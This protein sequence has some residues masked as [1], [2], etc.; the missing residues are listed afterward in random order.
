MFGNDEACLKAGRNITAGVRAGGVVRSGLLYVKGG[1]SNGRAT[2]SYR[3]NVAPVNNFN[4]SGN[5]DGWHVGAGYEL[6]I[7]ANTYAKIEYVFTNYSTNDNDFGIDADLQ[8]HQ[9][10]VGCNDSRAGVYWTSGWMGIVAS[11]RRLSHSFGSVA[12]TVEAA[13]W[14]VVGTR[15]MRGEP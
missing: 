9:G 13:A 1:Y 6:P 15:G 8:R 12:A 11:C 2:I 3:D 5:L 7:S 4:D 14:N 10:L